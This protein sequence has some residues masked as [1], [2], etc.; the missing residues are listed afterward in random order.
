MGFYDLL[1]NPRVGLHCRNRRSIYVAVIH[2]H[3]SSRIS[4]QIP[5]A[6]NIDCCVGN[7]K[8]VEQLNWITMDTR[9]YPPQVITWN[10]PG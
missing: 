10:L 5:G 3:S 7:K 6:V 9:N 8:Y 2:Q 1:V 4:E